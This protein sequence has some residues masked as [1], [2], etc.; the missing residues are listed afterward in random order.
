V[1]DIHNAIIFL[2]Q[3]KCV[4]HQHIGLIGWG[5]GASNVI[6]VA[7]HNKNVSAVA[8]LNGFYNGA[9]WLQT[10]HPYKNWID[11]LKTVEQDNINRVLSGKSEF[12]DTFIHYPLDPDT[13]DYVN[14]ELAQVKG[15]GYQTKLEFTDS[16]LELN[17]EKYV[18]D[19][20]PRPIFIG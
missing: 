9:R 5:M 7:A 19:I 13:E 16:L 14:K 10:I 15:F 1:K 3:Q 12:A 20:S 11:I 6:D 17:V 2:Q 18:K 8:A 4:N